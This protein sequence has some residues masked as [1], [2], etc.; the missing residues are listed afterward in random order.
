MGDYLITGVAIFLAAT[1]M[2]VFPLMSVSERTDDITQLTIQS[3]TTKFVDTARNTGKITSTTYG[4]FE[5]ELASTGNTYDIQVEVKVQDLNTKKI[6]ADAAKTKIGENLYYSLYNAQILE[7]L[8]NSQVFN[9]A[10]GDIISVN[11][12][13]TNKTISE[14]LR[15]FFYSISGNDSY[16]VAAAHSGIVMTNGK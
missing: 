2:F 1:L 3:A 12:K 6:G 13:N 8:D 4:A 7:E 10:E 11:V 15:G 5:Q 14:M 16:Q 9:L